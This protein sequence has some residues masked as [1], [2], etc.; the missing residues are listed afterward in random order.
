MHGLSRD[1]PFL[2]LSLRLRLAG[3]WNLLGILPLTPRSHLVV[4]LL[5]LVSGCG[6]LYKCCASISKRLGTSDM[7]VV[8]PSYQLDRKHEYRSS[9]ADSLISVSSAEST[10]E[11]T[12]LLGIVEL[13]PWPITVHT[14]EGL[15]W[16]LINLLKQSR[17]RVVCSCCS[18]ES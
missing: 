5:S 12:T 9:S 17:E 7:V 11:T 3:N 4:L 13:D 14:N 15:H 1:N 6:K 8:C 10:L 18:I 2:S 16:T